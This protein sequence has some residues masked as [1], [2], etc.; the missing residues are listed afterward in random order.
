MFLEFVKL[1]NN[2]TATNSG[3]N[4][5]AGYRA[6]QSL[7]SGANENTF[8][9][10]DSGK[11]MA[12]SS[13]NS[14]FG[15]RSGENATTASNVGIGAEALKANNSLIQAYKKNG[16]NPPIKSFEASKIIWEKLLNNC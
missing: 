8:F 14:Y 16:D 10:T 11:S 3:T 15:H 2:G 7:G 9:G 13:Y 6:G 1:D 4:A 12:G 5:Y